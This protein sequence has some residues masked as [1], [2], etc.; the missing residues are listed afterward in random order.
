M[1]EIRNKKRNLI[2]IWLDYKEKFDSFPHE[3]LI[4]SLHLE[5]LSE[6]LIRAI[7]NSTSKWCTFLH[8]NRGRR[9]GCVRYFTFCERNT[10]R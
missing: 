4:K 1:S 3:W 9:S 5:K 10:S 8:L 7:E 6:D 2:A